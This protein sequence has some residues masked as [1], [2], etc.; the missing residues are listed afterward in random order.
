MLYRSLLEAT[1][2]DFAG[3]TGADHPQFDE[4]NFAEVSRDGKT[5]FQ[6]HHE[7]DADTVTAFVILGVVPEDNRINLLTYA[8]GS[9]L[10]WQRT[11]GATLGLDEESMTLVVQQ[12]FPLQHSYAS[13]LQTSFHE[14]GK[15]AALWQRILSEAKRRAGQSDQNQA[16]PADNVAILGRLIA[17]QAF[18]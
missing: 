2:A 7:P 12:R 18:A 17:P 8:L 9:N 16:T 3:Q 13:S 14:L 10:F 11:R 1:L 15:V 6:F 5:V 4:Q